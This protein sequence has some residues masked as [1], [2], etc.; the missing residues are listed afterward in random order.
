MSQNGEHDA[1]PRRSRKHAFRAVGEEGGLLVDSDESK[2]H[3]LN[4]VGS[5]IY[6]MLDGRHTK[7]EI[8]RAVIAE[9]AVDERRA[10]DDLDAFLAQLERERSLDSVAPE[11]R[12]ARGGDE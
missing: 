11:S 1:A 12:A 3:V 10:R 9:F 8:V 6:S 7:D 5:K 4:P 2:V